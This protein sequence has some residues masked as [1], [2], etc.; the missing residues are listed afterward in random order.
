LVIL[1]GKIC[2][3]SVKKTRK[4]AKNQHFTFNI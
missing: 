2:K 3:K 1:G 4:M